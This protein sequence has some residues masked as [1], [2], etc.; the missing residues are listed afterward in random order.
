MATYAQIREDIRARHGF[1]AQSCWIAHV[2]EIAGLNPK[3]SPNRKSDKRVKPC[4]ASKVEIIK[5]SMRRFEMI[6]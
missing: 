1:V 2:K 6:P 4:P 5:D 3:R